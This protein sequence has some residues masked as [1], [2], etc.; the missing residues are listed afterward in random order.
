MISSTSIPDSESA[1]RRFLG[2]VVHPQPFYRSTD[3]GQRGR[4]PRSSEP[5]AP[6]LHQQAASHTR[7]S[8]R[9]ADLRRHLEPND[10]KCFRESLYVGSRKL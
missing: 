5:H 2:L 9:C 1:E 6:E 3:R 7:S 10:R 4:Q 8:A